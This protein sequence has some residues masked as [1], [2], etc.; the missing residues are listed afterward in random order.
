M[1]D[2]LVAQPSP[3]ILRGTAFHCLLQACVE[4]INEDGEAIILTNL[5]TVV[6]GP[7]SSVI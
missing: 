1:Q 2:R 4:E 6:V 3:A 5:D 7:E